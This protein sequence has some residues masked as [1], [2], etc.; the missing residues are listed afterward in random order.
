MVRQTSRN[1]DLASQLGHKRVVLTTR[2]REVIDSQTSFPHVRPGVSS[3]IN[4]NYCVSALRLLTRGK[5]TKLC[6]NVSAPPDR[7]TTRTECKLRSVPS[8][9]ASVRTDS[10][11]LSFSCKCKL[12]CKSCT[13]CS[14]AATKERCK[15]SCFKTTSVIKICEQCFLCRSV[16]FCKTC[17]KCPKCC[18]KSTFRGQVEPVFG[19]LGSLGGLTQSS[20]NVERGL[21][22]TFPNQTQLDQVIHNHQLLCTSSQ[23]P[24]PVG[25]IASAEKQKCSRVG[26]KSRISGLLQPA[27]LVPKPNHK[28]RS[29]L[30]LSN[31]NKFLKAQKFK[32]E[33]S[34]TIQL[35]EWVIDYK[36]TY[37]HIPIQN[38]SRKYQI[39]GTGQNI[40]V[41][42]TAIWSSRY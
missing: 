35:G 34:E 10:K 24:L 11:L 12:S 28:W 38:Q 1:K 33:T 41:Q 19:N 5:E 14:R 6:K 9:R 17:T 16:V 25:G 30:D 37:F 21:Y 22:P 8:D 7:T 20:T 26:Q 31:L 13:Y 40:P 3:H 32:M 15:S 2:E 18:T 36:D 39:S 42:S 27:F 29:I 23:E 4:D